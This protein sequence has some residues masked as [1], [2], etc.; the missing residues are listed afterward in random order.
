MNYK[1]SYRLINK[2]ASITREIRVQAKSKTLA[3]ATVE[4]VVSKPNYRV[5]IIKVD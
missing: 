2:K 5:E 3:K 4:R 1:I